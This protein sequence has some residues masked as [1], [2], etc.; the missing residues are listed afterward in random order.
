[1][2]VVLAI[3]GQCSVDISELLAV[4]GKAASL[5]KWFFYWS[6]FSIVHVVRERTPDKSRDTSCIHV[7]EEPSLVYLFAH[8]NAERALERLA[9][10]CY[11]VC[12]PWKL[13]TFDS[14]DKMILSRGLP[15]AGQLCL[16]PG[17]LGR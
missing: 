7:D 13:K 3:K 2:N 16:N 17:K 15:I 9:G 6:A 11:D 12:K 14:A 10:M 1:M 5:S 8:D 4:R